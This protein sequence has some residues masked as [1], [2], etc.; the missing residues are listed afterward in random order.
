MTTLTRIILRP[1][2]CVLAVLVVSLPVNAAPEI[3]AISVRGLQ[4][5]GT[6][7]IRVNGTGLLPEPQLV[8][9]VPIT[10]QVVKPG[11]K[12][13]QVEFEVALAGN[14]EPGLYNVWLASGEGVSQPNVV[15]LDRLPQLPFAA[16]VASIPVA[17]HGTIGGSARLRTSFAAKAGQ[18]LLIEVEAQRLGGKLRPVLH[19][20]NSDNQQLDW[21]LPSPILRG[22]ARLKFTPPADGTYTIE[23]HDLQYAAPAP[24]FFRLKIGSWQYADLVFPPAVQSGSRVQLTLISDGADGP[25]VTF[26]ASTPSADLFRST[27]W[28][29]AKSST[30]LRPPVL[31]SQYAEVVE[32]APSDTPQKLP[33]TPSAISG[34][35]LTPGEQD[36]YQVD[37]EP[38]AKLR[39]DV[40]AAQLGSPV[41]SIL[42]I[43]NETGGRLALND[44]ANGSPDSRV[45]YTVPAN[46]K[47]VFVVVKDTNGRS[48]PNCMYRMV[49]T[50]LLG[51]SGTSDFQLRIEQ[52][53]QTVATGDRIV[54]RVIAERDGFDG[55]INLQFDALPEGIQVQGGTIPAGASG[56]L[57]TLHGA[58]LD[59]AH[60]LTK[61]RGVAEIAGRSFERIATVRTHVLGKMQP[62]LSGEFGVAVATPSP[63]GFKADWGALGSDTRFV[64]GGKLDLPVSATR[65][66]GFDGPVRLTLETSQRPVM[67]NV[68]IDANRTLRSETNKPIELAVDAAAQNAWNAKQATDKVVAD[69]KTMQATIAETGRKAVAA[70]D[71]IAKDVVAKL[72]VM[73]SQATKAAA[74]AKQAGDAD[75]VAQKALD[76]AAAQASAAA[77]ALAKVDKADAAKLA[78][79]EKAVA[80]ATALVK[81]STDQK[82]A[83]ATALAAVTAVAKKAS[84]AVIVGEKAVADAMTALKT[85]TDTA[86]KADADAGAKLKDAETKLDVAV[87]AAQ[88]A[89]A[90][91]KNDA[92]FSI[93]V[94]AELS[95]AGY[96]VALRAELLSRDKRTVIA[97][98]DTSVRRFTTLVPIVVSVSGADQFAGE[99]DPKAGIKITMAGK[100]ERLAGMNQAVSVTLS[101]LPAG[102]AV[103]KVVVKPDQTDFKLDVAFPATFKPAQL[104]TVRLFATGKMR[105]NAPIDVRSK[106]L[107]LTISLTAKAEPAEAP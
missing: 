93:F 54:V 39:F 17:L 8:L 19:V 98:S 29:D 1:I 3:S 9:S 34:R 38:G 103:P 95:E 70:A 63:S 36:K 99:I 86:Q 71:V 102:I 28:L 81:T 50:P 27:P 64:L 35:F 23:L 33:A 66:A 60:V 58:G 94:P 6:T 37:V 26:D 88:S 77:D 43:Q 69:A 96:E 106:E 44:D 22:D 11:A 61:L 7:T 62:W 41:D 55:Q 15:A 104:T 57:M 78:E 49:V 12:A 31:V 52:Q 105:P 75:A 92:T 32:S 100:V 14:I 4:I 21:T 30:G 24:N 89:A 79:A 10:K 18:P 107:P 47:T 97:R 48:G 46:V 87:K 45:D 85:A 83:T 16:E 67:N 76:A 82:T 101:G 74:T 13:T 90:L 84:D 2:A 80:D 91:A 56:T 65:P 25:S 42:E 59:Q 73:K 53:R 5:D 20:F 72:T 40:F 51:S 68:Q